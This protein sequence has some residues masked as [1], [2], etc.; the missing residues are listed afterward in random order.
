MTNVRFRAFVYT[1]LG[2][3]AAVI[4]LMAIVGV[5]AYRVYAKQ[6]DRPWIRK[7]AAW[8]RLPAARVG[9]RRIGYA[10]YLKHIDA[11][12]L[13]L[14]GQQARAQGL[15]LVPDTDM[16]RQT[17]NRLLRMAA[18][19]E[20][21]DERGM[22]LTTADVDRA[23]EE[24]IARA[25]TSTSAGEV[26]SFLREQFGWGVGDFKQNVI[27]PAMLEDG[28]RNKKETETKD[29]DAFEAELQARLSQ[30]DVKRFLRI[31]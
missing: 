26:E 22:A 24:L 15:P 10:E 14:K 13:V 12:R 20:F 18:V 30:G 1:A 6:D 19:E 17:L 8:T 27:R 29:P 4:G 25:G 28:L 7:A 11:V 21:A 9:S 31:E 5:F 3:S 16:R 23:Y 2:A